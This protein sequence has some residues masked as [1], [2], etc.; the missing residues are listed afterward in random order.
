MLGEL[1]EEVVARVA[2]EVVAQ[3]L[4]AAVAEL[5]AS[6]AALPQPLRGV[7]PPARVVDDRGSTRPMS[8]KST[9]PVVRNAVNCALSVSAM[10]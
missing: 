8:E 2:V 6:A 7:V 9:R 4:V 5:A 1:D 3:L 10:L